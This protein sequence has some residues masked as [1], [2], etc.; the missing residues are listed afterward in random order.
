[1][2]KTTYTVTLLS[3][4]QLSKLLRLGG[5][6][7]NIS[8]SDSARELFESYWREPLSNVTDSAQIVAVTESKSLEDVLTD[9]NTD[10]RILKQVKSYFKKMLTAASDDSEKEVAGILYHTAIAAA[11]VFHKKRITSLSYH[12]LRDAFTLIGKTLYLP[13]GL[14]S[15]LLSGQGCLKE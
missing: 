11:L 10:I 12:D 4:S 8:E 7:S 9:S 15:L 1:M 13:A 6:H 3:S 2:N 14:K 5:G